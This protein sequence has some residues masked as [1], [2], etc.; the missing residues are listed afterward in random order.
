MFFH[1]MFPS[2]STIRWCGRL[3]SGWCL[4]ATLLGAAFAPL[5]N[6][7]AS[8]SIELTAKV[9]LP[10]VDFSDTALQQSCQHLIHANLQVKS[11]LRSVTIPE[12]SKFSSEVGRLSIPELGPFAVTSLLTLGTA[13]RL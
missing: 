1:L 4:L 11:Y 13:L 5:P 10:T 8:Q 2:H 9:V 3:L 7:H 12:G 6:S